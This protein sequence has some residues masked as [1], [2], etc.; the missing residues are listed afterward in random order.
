MVSSDGCLLFLSVVGLR[1]S[2]PEITVVQAPASPDVAWPIILPIIGGL[3]SA[4]DFGCGTGHWL[5]SLT[6]QIHGIEVLGFN[7]PRRKDA[8]T[9]LPKENFRYAD[10]TK[11]LDL[12]RKFDLAI[13]I[14]VAEHLPA[15]AADTL[16]DTITRHSDVVFFGAAIPG[17]DGED[18]FNE[19]WPN[20]WIERFASRGFRCFD[21][22]R[23][24]VW[25]NPGISIWY[26][27]NMT[28][29]M[30]EPRVPATD[31]DDWHGVPVVHPA[32]YERLLHVDPRSLEGRARALVKRVLG[33][34][35][36]KA[37]RS[38]A[39]Y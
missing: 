27:Q 14:E 36:T 37:V 9:F 18:H 4:V 28:L 3:K 10:L 12:G 5:S 19:Q 17:Q 25:Q 24:I 20:Y 32:Y 2:L 16:V 6:R 8:G 35:L 21:R 30:R 13:C 38:A 1:K 26:R 11:P 22:L 34:K 7:S 23:P 31:G 39:G 33:P 15:S 29:F